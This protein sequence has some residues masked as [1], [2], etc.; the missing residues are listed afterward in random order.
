MYKEGAVKS[1]TSVELAKLA[2][3]SQSTISRCLNDSPY[4]AEATKE[5]VKKIAE[6]Y[7][8][9]F[10]SNARGLKT[11][12]TGLIGYIFSEDFEGFANHYIQSNLYFRIREKLIKKGLDVVPVF[13]DLTSMGISTIE[14]NIS[15]RRFDALIFNRPRI[16]QRIKNLL[17]KT[18]IPHFFMYDTDAS[19]DG[20][21]MISPNHFESGYLVGKTF[22][23]HGY[24]NFVEVTGPSTRIDVI[25]KHKGFVAALKK[26]RRYLPESHILN[27]TYKV[28]KAIE[29]TESHSTLFKR[30]TAC[31]AQNDMTALGV[32]EGLRRHRIRVPEDVVVI[33]Y[34][35]IPMSEWFK[36]HLTT[37]AIDYTKIIEVA[38]EWIVEMTHGRLPQEHKV[39]I[40][41]GLIMRDTFTG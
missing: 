27:G 40:S 30:G 1:I 22:C 19:I 25:N 15:N 6:E 34:D 12:K 23:E 32:L 3:V 11:N 28:E 24:A 13:D 2:N 39:V 5:R 18:D 41:G 36:P 17:T 21:Y 35:N 26:Y 33:G 37:V 20:E 16:N 31:F 14:M 29:L 38:V 9:Q 8:F 10:N 4:V 7:S